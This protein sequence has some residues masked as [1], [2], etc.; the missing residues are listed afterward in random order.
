MSF[1]YVTIVSYNL[2]AFRGSDVEE[3][4]SEAVADDL[5]ERQSS[6]NGSIDILGPWGYK[7]YL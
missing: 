4:I 2:R 6:P 7:E 3:Y 1:I 5:M